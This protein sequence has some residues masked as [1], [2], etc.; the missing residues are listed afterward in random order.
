MY[1]VLKTPVGLPACHDGQD[2][3]SKSSSLL[4]FLSI[5][6]DVRTDVMQVLSSSGLAQGVV[7]SGGAG[8]GLQ[9]S[10]PEHYS[11][12]KDFCYIRVFTDKIMNYQEAEALC[13]QD[14][15]T[16][17]VIASQD[18]NDYVTQMLY[19]RPGWIGLSNVGVGTFQWDDWTNWGQGEP[20]SNGAFY[21]KSAAFGSATGDTFNDQ[22]NHVKV[23]RDG[24]CD[25]MAMVCGHT[26]QPSYFH[27]VC[28]QL[29]D[30]PGTAKHNNTEHPKDCCVLHHKSR[31][32]SSQIST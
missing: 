25:S 12:Y 27:R 30:F 18:E 23:R 13:A 8:I 16:L 6:C 31:W 21:T 14:G 28:S 22:N 2:G 20:S 24:S 7:M 10:C 26:C 9:G 29:M 17:A 32:L 15:A 5:R 4:L 11:E 19:Q 3:Q 1:A